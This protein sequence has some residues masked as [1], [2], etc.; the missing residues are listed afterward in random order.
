MKRKSI[1]IQLEILR[2][3][4]KNPEITISKL[5]RKIR[6]N[7]GSLREHCK[8]LELFELIIIGKKNKLSIT[9]HGLKITK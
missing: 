8:H 5:E 3:I 2:I 9:K 6:T 1:E 7:P 4:K